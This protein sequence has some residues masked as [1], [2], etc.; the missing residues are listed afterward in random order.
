MASTE[1]NFGPDWLRALQ[2]G[3]PKG[4]NSTSASSS[5]SMFAGHAPDIF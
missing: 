3:M 4:S 1:M 5:M 2:D